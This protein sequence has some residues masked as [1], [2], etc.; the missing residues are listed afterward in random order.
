MATVM[1]PCPT[2]KQPTPHHT[3]GVHT[4]QRER[5]GRVSQ[6]MECAACKTST[7][8]YF[9]EGTNEFQENLDLPDDGDA[10]QKSATDRG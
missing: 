7:R 9:T 6:M 10:Q 3:T 5:D 8:V 1:S 2:C 4:R